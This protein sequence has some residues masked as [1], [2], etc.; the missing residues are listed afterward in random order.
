MAG[1]SHAVRCVEGPVARCIPK[2]DLVDQKAHREWTIVAEVVVLIPDV[3][4]V[5]I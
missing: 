2:V 1:E 3:H 5:H 4:M